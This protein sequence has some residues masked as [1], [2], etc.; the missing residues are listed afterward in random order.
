[1]EKS[2]ASIG[3]FLAFPL[4]PLTATI[5]LKTTAEKKLSATYWIKTFKLPRI[6]DTY[7]QEKC[8]F[9]FFFFAM[10]AL[11]KYRVRFQ[12]FFRNDGWVA[13]PPDSGS[14]RVPCKVFH[15]P[16]PPE[17]AGL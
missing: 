9:S 4:L 2:S 10:V 15:C 7:F 16:Y 5:A 14:D 6:R 1:M 11:G 13:G 8:L 3:Y 17:N 12:P